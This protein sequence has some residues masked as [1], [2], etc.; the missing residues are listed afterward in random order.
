MDA[1][2]QHPP[3]TAAVLASTAVR[4]HC[5]IVVGTRYASDRSAAD[6]LGSAGRVFVSSYVTRLV[7]NLFP[8]RLALVSDPL[9]GLFVFRRASV[10]LDR[11]R[12]VGFKVLLEILVRNPVARIA[13]VAYR[14]EPR[15]AGESKASLLQGATFLRH[16]ARLRAARLANGIILMLLF[17]VRFVLSDRAI[18]ASGGQDT[19]RDPVRVL[20]DLAGPDDDE[21][22]ANGSGG[23]APAA[24]KRS[25]YLTYRY[26]VAGVVTLG[27]QVMLPELEFFRAQW[28]A[29]RDV[30]IAVR[31]GDVG[32]SRPRRRAAMIESI[33]PTV[34]RY[35]EHLGRLGANF[36]AH[37]DE[38]ITVDVGPLLAVLELGDNQYPVGRYQSYE[39][40]FD[41]S[42]GR[43]KAI[44][45]PV[46]GNHEY[47]SRDASGYYQY[48]G[49]A[50]G[51]P[52][53]GYYSFDLRRWHLIALNAECSFIA[54]CSPGS[55]EERWLAADLRQHP[56]ACI[57]AYWHQPRFS[58]GQHGDDPVYDAFWRDLF[59]AHADVVLNGHDHDY[60]RFAPQAP[61]G[62]ADP[63]GV[64]EFVVGTGGKSHY[65]FK[66]IQ[67][68][69]V[70]RN[71]TAAGATGRRRLPA[72][73]RRAVRLRLP[74]RGR[75]LRQPGRPGPA[76]ALPALR[77][78]RGATVR[79]GG[80][81][82]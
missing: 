16:L 68:N 38:R 14:F 64:T 40:Y 66:N 19:H 47:L 15:A 75:G 22:C 35:E 43:F 78:P 80:P 73:H 1:D 18:F 6:G 5:D 52:G 58:S 82:L 30:D 60:E 24:R 56:A 70:A 46:P 69:S 27:S 37:I 20:V 59:A 34:I 21:S 3:E 48:F 57:L 31:V 76:A 49:P 74:A 39:R 51:D 29:D 7:K 33:H 28:I 36:R 50:G 12:P 4:H 54:G 41:P 8:R 10:N 32:N 9:S 13:E 11:L 17:A 26:D 71:D 23:Q 44:S 72:D 63:S 79:P 65:R 25:R 62:R 45:H 42:W 2:L 77:Q 67:P 55:A 53:R 61:A 81:R